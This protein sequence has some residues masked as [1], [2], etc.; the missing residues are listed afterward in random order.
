MQGHR[1]RAARL[2]ALVALDGAADPLHYQWCACGRE[3]VGLDFHQPGGRR[4]ATAAGTPKPAPPTAEDAARI[5][6]AAWEQDLDWGTLIWLK[7][8]TGAR[9]GELCALRWYDVHLAEAVLEIRRNYTRR[10]RRSTEKD[11]KTH[12]MRRLGLDPETVEVLTEHRARLAERLTALGVQGSWAAYVFS[13]EPDHSRPCN[14]DGI[15]HRYARMCRSLGIDITSTTCG[16]MPRP[17]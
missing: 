16:T 9:R 13:Y 8:V 10:N 15:S 5:L 12:Q 14:P 3:A 1:V 4:Q 11:T 2:R 17:S 7:M 6:A